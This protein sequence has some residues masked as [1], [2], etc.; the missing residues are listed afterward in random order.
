MRLFMRSQKR[1]KRPEEFPTP[2]RPRRGLPDDVALGMEY[3]RQ[4]VW[5][6]SGGE[7]DQET[8]DALAEA[9]RAYWRR[10]ADSNRLA[11]QRK[12]EGIFN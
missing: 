5:G 1:R 8:L 11:S 4:R 9:D 10:E 6:G 2:D 12:V 7:A 3:R